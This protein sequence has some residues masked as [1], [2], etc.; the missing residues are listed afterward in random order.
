[1]YP[2]YSPLNLKI[3]NLGL[4][5]FFRELEI[6]VT[7]AREQANLLPTRRGAGSWVTPESP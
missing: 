7:K 3:L 1:M 5:I 6:V 2:V 4:R